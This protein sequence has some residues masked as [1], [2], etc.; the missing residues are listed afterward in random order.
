MGHTY[1]RATLPID[2]AEDLARAHRATGRSLRDTASRIG[3][4]HGYWR[5]LMRGERCPST[6]VAQRIIDALDLPP[7][8]AVE[9]MS[10]AVV[11]SRDREPIHSDWR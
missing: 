6:I 11:R 10:V 7:E 5:R 9:L 3:I 4:D 8:V 2:L 1:Q